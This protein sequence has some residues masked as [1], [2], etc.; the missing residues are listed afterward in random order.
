LP[1]SKGVIP[2][3]GSEPAP[4]PGARVVGTVEPDRRIQV[5]VQVRPRASAATDD[6]IEAMSE[7]P[8]E[9]RHY[10]SSAELAK[11]H[12]AYPAELA[13]VEAFAHAHGLEVVSSSIPERIIVL[14]GP[15]ATIAAVFG[16]TLQRYE[17]PGGS[18]YGPSGAIHLPVELI[19]FVE[20]VSGLSD[21]PLAETR[22]PTD[23]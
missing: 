23:P 5:T 21:R 4:H 6:E 3:P 12:G 16:V 17:H 14:A 13:A 1:I 19:P 15:A 20:G 7:L 11:R 9:Q 2:L 22:R 8:L 18:Y 10:P